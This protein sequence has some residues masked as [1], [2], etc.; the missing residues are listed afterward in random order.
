MD[1]TEIMVKCLLEPEQTQA[2]LEKVTAF[3]SSYAKALKRAG[4]DGLV[5]ADLLAGAFA[6][7]RCDVFE[8]Y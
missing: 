7:R 2:V 3:I 1:E 8:R 4:A 6:S 5:L